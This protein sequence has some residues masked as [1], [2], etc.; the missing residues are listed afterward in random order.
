MNTQANSLHPYTQTELKLVAQGRA[1]LKVICTL[2]LTHVP[3]VLYSSW[4]LQQ[5]TWGH[6]VRTVGRLWG[7]CSP[8]PAQQMVWG[9]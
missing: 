4:Y 8:P 3:Y 6:N 9:T 2:L 1:Q 7:P 5:D